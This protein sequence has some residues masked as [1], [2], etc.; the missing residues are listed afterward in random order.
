[1]RKNIFGW[2]GVIVGLAGAM[3][4]I[5]ATINPMAV[6]KIF[7]QIGPQNLATWL[8]IGTIVFTLIMVLGTMGPFIISAL[9]NSAKKKRLAQTG[10]RTK[11]SIVRI[12]DTGITIND[13][14][15]IKITVAIKPGVE[16]TFQ[17]TVSRLQIPH[18]GDVI[19]VVYDP[20]DMTCVLPIS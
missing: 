14:P 15:S 5:Y 12:Q 6:A 17:K 16:A 19:E 18:V 1:M 9:D 11:A 7:M 8:P 13:N 20:A 10:L 4:G 2:I 3:L